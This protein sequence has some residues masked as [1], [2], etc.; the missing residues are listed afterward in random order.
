MVAGGDD[1]SW[2]RGLECATDELAVPADILGSVVAGDL[3]PLIL[4]YDHALVR[5]G[6]HWRALR[7]DRVDIEDRILAAA[8]GPLGSVRVARI[9][10]S[11]KAIDH[12]RTLEASD[13]VG[14]GQ[15]GTTAVRLPD[16]GWRVTGLDGQETTITLAA[17]ETVLGAT[18]TPAT[19]PALIVASEGRRVLRVRGS[20]TLTLT[21]AS[22]DLRDLAVHPTQP[23]LAVLRE[24]GS[25]EVFS[26]A[27]GAR[28]VAVSGQP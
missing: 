12:G 28:L 25:L 9:G 21:A 5:L 7:P 8:P 6:P 11:W 1:P 24:R 10:E 17:G 2:L 16:G 27:T 19:G 13:R 23:Y 3:A 4:S 26:L 22:G 15:L 20:A 14:F 18:Q